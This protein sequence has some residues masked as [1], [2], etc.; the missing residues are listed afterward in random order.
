MGLAGM[1]PSPARPRPG[2]CS[3]LHTFFR[4]WHGAQRMGETQ[5]AL[6]QSR[7]GEPGGELGSGNRLSPLQ[8][9]A[10]RATG[11]E[12]SSLPAVH[13]SGQDLVCP[14]GRRAMQVSV[15][16]VD[17]FRPQGGEA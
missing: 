7:S 2:I 12:A 15:R 14:G 17:P 10:L 4:A 1:T 6:E 5:S 16:P 9:P 11:K 3:L 13:G 8:P